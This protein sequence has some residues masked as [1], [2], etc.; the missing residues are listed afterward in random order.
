MRP[1]RHPFICTIIVL[2]LIG[3]SSAGQQRQVDYRYAP[4]W[5]ASCISFPDDTCKTLVGPEGQLLYHFG[6]KRYFPYANDRGFRTVIHFL[7]DEAVLFQQQQL[8]DARIPIVQ[9]TARLQGMPV[10]QEAIAIAQPFTQQ[11]TSTQ[12]GNR[13]DLLLTRI[14][15][16]GNS[17]KT[18]QPVVVINTEYAVQVQQQT[19]TITDSNKVYRLYLDR[20]VQR[21]RQNLTDSSFKTIIELA[22]VIVPAGDSIVLAALYDNGKPSLLAQQF[23]DRPSSFLPALETART[24][25]IQYWQHQT[26]IPY[27]HITVPD[28]EIQRLLDAS[29]RG[30]WQAREIKN[31]KAAFQVGPTCYRGLWIVDGAFL[32]EAVTML[33]RGKEARD[34]IDYMLSFQEP[35]GRFGKMSADYYKENGIVLWTCV[36]H[37]LLTQDKEWLTSKWPLLRK[38]VDYIKELRKQTLQNKDPLDDGL[39]PAGEIDG[40]LWGSADKAEYTNVYWNLAGLKAMIQAAEWLGI[41]KD[42]RDW[43]KEYS[44]FYDRFQQAARRDQA[45][46]V[47]GNTYLNVV[48]D[49]AKRS[50]P[51]R[52][53]WAFCQAIYPGQVFDKNDPISRGTMQM[54]QGTLQEGM[55][56]GTGWL[57]DGIWNY[58]ASFYGHASLWLGEKQQAIESL[59]AFANHASPLYAWREEHT[60]RDLQAK[61]VGDMPHNW[62]SAEF[63]RLVTHLLALDRG[64]ELHLFEGLPAEW[65][66]AGMT[67]RFNNVHTVFGPLTFTLQVDSTGKTAQLQVAPLKDSS[68]TG[69]YVHTLQSGN[70]NT[71]VPIKLDPRKTNTLTLTI[72]E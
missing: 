22:P 28:V 24:A 9:T 72:P 16:P 23:Q 52:A 5:Q 44:D 30:I 6:G 58:F 7:A 11:G 27:D 37:A 54:L 18:I 26:P 61:Y 56:I 60:P 66:Q 59:Y 49:P 57:I 14:S 40:G 65:L 17:T 51:Q 1:Y 2:L 38:T 43:Q 47:L 35:G 13:E 45:Q 12:Q 53:Q 15:N 55:V 25:M 63:V 33:N 34:G 4:A 50:L 71:G 20:P 32:L 29:L 36:R 70:S 68:C 64:R 10:Q 8:L 41:K 42:A 39:I 31:G 67:T 48:M 19:V 3:L 46:D 21:V 69:I 62:G